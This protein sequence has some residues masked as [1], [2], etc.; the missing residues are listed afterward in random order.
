MV[1]EPGGPLGAGKGPA[2]G[3][4]RGKCLKTA[5][6]WPLSGLLESEGR[7]KRAARNRGNSG[8]LE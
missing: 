2:Q 5:E 8:P 4:R 3:L 1:S 6:Q 7:A